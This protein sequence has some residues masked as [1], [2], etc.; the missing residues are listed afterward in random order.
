MCTLSGKTCKG[1][2]IQGFCKGSVWG[3]PRSNP[4][5]LKAPTEALVRSTLH[6]GTCKTRT[7]C[8][9]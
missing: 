2:M 3:E 5:R 1:E 4:C 9:R 8:Y 6:H 7:R